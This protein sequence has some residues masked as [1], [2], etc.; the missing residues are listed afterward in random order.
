MKTRNFSGFNLLTV[1]LL[2]FTLAVAGTASAAPVTI[3]LSNFV[4]F[5]GGTLTIDAG[6]ETS[7]GGHVLINGN[8]GSNQDLFM[9]GNPLPGYPAQLNGAAYAGG[10]LTFGQDLTVGSSTELREVVANGAATIGSGVTIWGTLDALSATLGSSP[11]PVITGGVTAPSSKTFALI[12]MPA[13]TVFTAGGANQTVPTGQGNSLTLAPGTYGALAT[14]SQ[15]QTVTLSSGNYYFDSITTQGGFDLQID[16]TSGNCINIYVVGNAAFAGQQTLLVKGTGTGGAFVPISAA[17]ALASLIY[18]ETRARF[19]M[20]GGVDATHNVWGGTVYASFLTGGSPQVVIGQYTDWYGAAYALDSFD[21]A[22]HGKW[23]NVPLTP[24]TTTTTVPP[25]TTT[26]PPTTTT[27][28]PTTTTTVPTTLIELSTFNAIPGNKKVTLE[29]VTETEIDNAGFN[30]YRAE[31]EDGEYVQINEDLIPA[32]G[33]GMEGA[34][35]LFIDNKAKNRKAYYYKLE[36]M[37]LSGVS[38]MHGPVSATPSF[39]LGLSLRKK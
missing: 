33:S 27:V 13:A 34:S 17:P 25:T 29:W 20:T 15:N 37:D 35:Y 10:K 23:T 30:I 5:S 19:T 12:T 11:A 22:D 21:T 6:F 9:Q 3:P 24:C 36:D 38:T 8:I 4:I 39:I 1:A 31:E 16:L 2:V 28:Q 14:S 32:N 18:L 26:V 7:I